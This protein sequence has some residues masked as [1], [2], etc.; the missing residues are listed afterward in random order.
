MAVHYHRI[1]G[2]AIRRQRLDLPS[3]LSLESENYP[4][5]ENYPFFQPEKKISILSLENHCTTYA[6]IRTGDLRVRITRTYR[7]NAM[8]VFYGGRAR[9]RPPR[10]LRA[11]ARSDPTRPMH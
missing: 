2:E 11:L 4:L 6:E 3:L 1:A 7:E 9:L 5:S 10:V 8:F